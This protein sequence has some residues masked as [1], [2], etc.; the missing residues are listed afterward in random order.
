MITNQQ[1][2]NRYVTAINFCIA[3]GYHIYCI[4]STTIGNVKAIRVYN[5]SNG[6]EGIIKLK[7]KKYKPLELY[8]MIINTVGIYETEI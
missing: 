3:Q 7:P 4:F 5:E 6:K 8:H 2:W 1:R